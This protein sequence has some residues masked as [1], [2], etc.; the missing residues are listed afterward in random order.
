MKRQW[1]MIGAIILLL[2]VAILSVLNV[3]SVP[4][5]FGFAVVEWPLIIIIF[6]SILLGA[7][8]A[9][10]LSTVKSYKDKREHTNESKPDSKPLTRTDK[11]SKNVDK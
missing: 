2:L 9:T 11:N 8:I 3:D 10:L 4:L 5:N 1:S 6:V 7:V